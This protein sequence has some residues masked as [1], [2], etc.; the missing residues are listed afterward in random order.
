MT[1]KELME[2]LKNYDE[3][4]KVELV[5]TFVFGEISESYLKIKE[6]EFLKKIY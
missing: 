6:D 2:I 5:N 1:V 3:N 4:D